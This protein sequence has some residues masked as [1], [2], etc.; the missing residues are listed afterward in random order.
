MDSFAELFNFDSANENFI[1]ESTMELVDKCINKQSAKDDVLDSPVLNESFHRQFDQFYDDV[2]FL[3]YF[4]H[5]TLSFGNMNRQSKIHKSI[6]NLVFALCKV[7]KYFKKSLKDLKKYHQ[8]LRSLKI[9]D[10]SFPDVYLMELG[11]GFTMAKLVNL[12]VDM[13]ESVMGSLGYH[14]YM[15][16]DS[17]KF[18]PFKRYIKY[19]CYEFVNFMNLFDQKNPR[20]YKLIYQKDAERAFHLFG[21]PSLYLT[22]DFDGELFEYIQ[23]V[24]IIS[25]IMCDCN[26]YGGNIVSKLVS[27]CDQ[28]EDCYDYLEFLNVTTQR[29]AAYNAIRNKVVLTLDD[30]IN[31]GKYSSFDDLYRVV[32]IARFRP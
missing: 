13:A 29:T 25:N 20:L 6:A 8:C 17:E 22:L 12:Y 23:M 10:Y 14:N 16:N 19:E 32:R 30:V 21:H 11:Y 4:V 15:G 3:M 27:L 7:I 9:D 31:W 24:S 1:E 26:Q 28:L 2:F 18:S 5:Q